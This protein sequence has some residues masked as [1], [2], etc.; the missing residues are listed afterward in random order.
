MRKLGL[1]TFLLLLAACAAVEP[2]PRGLEK[3]NHVVVRYQENWSFDSLF[4]K[5]PGANG[6]ANAG[7][8]LPQSDRSG[9]VYALLPPS[10]GADNKPDP[11]ILGNLPNAPFDLG[12]F[13]APGEK[14][15]NPT[16]L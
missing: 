15:G 2:P 3:I 6:L 5:F 7:S 1:A 14:T 4:G 10:T 8:A 11:R 16:H 9:N 13:V 12:R